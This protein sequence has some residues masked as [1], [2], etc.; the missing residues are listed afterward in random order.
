MTKNSSVVSFFHF[1]AGRRVS[2]RHVAKDVVD[3]HRD[4]KHGADDQVGPV[5]I[6][7][8]EVDALDDDG[9]SDCAKENAEYRTEAARQQHTADDYG[10]DGIEDKV[11]AA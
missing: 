10:N 1:H 9:E 5:A 4:Q 7:V 3:E 2:Q 6:N 11:H 8:R